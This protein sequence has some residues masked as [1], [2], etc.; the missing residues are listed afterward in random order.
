MDSRYIFEVLIASLYIALGIV[1]FAYIRYYPFLDKLRFSKLKTIIMFSLLVL[2]NIYIFIKIEK[3]GT[4]LEIENSGVFRVS[5]FIVYF[6]FSCI[7]IKENFFK[8]CLIYLVC[9]MFITTLTVTVYF[10]DRIFHIDIPYL[11]HVLIM[12]IFTVPFATLNFL[13]TKRVLTPL[14]NKADVKTSM[15]ICC[16]L[17]IILVINSFATYDLSW[18]QSFPIKYIIIRLFSFLGTIEVIVILKRLVEEQENRLILSEDCK[19]QEVLLAIQKEQFYSLSEK[20]E[21]TKRVRHDLKHHFAAMQVFL[22]QKEYDKLSE[23]I[24]KEIEFVPNE[25]KVIFCENITVNA[26]LS[27]YYKKAKNINSRMEVKASIPDRLRLE[28]TELWVIF[29]NLLENAIEGCERVRDKERKIKVT[30]Y[31][32]DTT[33][34]ILVDNV[35]NE[36][37]IKK[38]PNGFISSKN[39]DVHGV[40]IESIRFLAKKLDGGADFEVK[41]GWFLASVYIRTQCI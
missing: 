22:L 39:S 6:I 10:I 28:D 4:F 41:N 17:F 31:Y 3:N 34:F 18:K 21:E 24:Q 9:F 5:F 11:T 35:V 2:L 29:G 38:S 19:R 14:I 27:Y 32:K 30:I 26:I 40:G 8:H 36:E 7:S 25:E 13:F 12:I 37:F 20:I 16:I 33:L 1:P 15:S 23:Y